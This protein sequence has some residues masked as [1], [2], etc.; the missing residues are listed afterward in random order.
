MMIAKQSTKKEEED[1]DE[2]IQ[3]VKIALDA[4]PIVS[5]LENELSKLNS[6]LLQITEIIIFAADVE[7]QYNEKR[8]QTIIAFKAD[9]TTARWDQVRQMTS[10]EEWSQVKE[11]LVV[12]VLKQNTQI[13]DKIELLL[14]DG[15]YKQVIEV[16]PH[17]TGKDEELD[18][19]LQVYKTIEE[20]DPVLLEKMIPVVSRYMKRYFQEQKY[21]SMYP[22][23]DRFQRRFPG[24]ITSLLAN[25]CDTVM[26]G[27]LPS[28][29]STFVQMLKHMKQRLES[30]NKAEDWE[31]FFKGF[32]VKHMGKKRLIQMI[33]LLGDSSWNMD[34]IFAMQGE[35]P[36]II[37]EQPESRE[38]RPKSE[39]KKKRKKHSSHRKKRKTTHSEEDKE[40]SYKE[41][42]RKTTHSEREKDK[43]EA[44]EEGSENEQELTLSEANDSAPIK[45]HPSPSLVERPST[46][47]TESV[48]EEQLTPAKKQKDKIEKEHKEKK[49]SNDGSEHKL[50]T[51]KKK[52]QRE[53]K[54]K[55]RRIRG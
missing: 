6:Q 48:E 13:K 24:I 50:K 12:Y 3:A 19:L 51:K 14:K 23:L 26:F 38:T 10:D 41:K 17:P 43:E 21:D 7:K 18:L 32:K 11:E 4:A 9:T 44:E 27:I 1:F 52:S 31:T 40:L 45:S 53:P 37:K 47:E 42:K 33:N 20:K 29:Y 15:L 22:M 54:E 55:K 25:A 46:P 36:P 30:I 5:D 2:K 35:K 8:S 28:Q 16:F 49:E 34:K 39:K